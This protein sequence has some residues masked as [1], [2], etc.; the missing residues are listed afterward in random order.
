MHVMATFRTFLERNS[1]KTG[2]G[3]PD[4]SKPVIKNCLQEG[5]ELLL[6]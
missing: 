5:D 1:H 3:M 2:P 6:E 4:S